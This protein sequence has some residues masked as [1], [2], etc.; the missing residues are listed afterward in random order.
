MIRVFIIVGRKR[1]NESVTTHEIQVV[2]VTPNMAAKNS[3][4]ADD[5]G[6]LKV[7]EQS[8]GRCMGEGGSD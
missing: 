8:L 4:A 5:R 2:L 7:T 6:K 3:M 1:L